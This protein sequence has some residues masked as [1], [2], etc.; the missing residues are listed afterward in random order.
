MAKIFFVVL[1]LGG[2]LTYLGAPALEVAAHE[3]PRGEAVAGGGA[4]GL[5]SHSTVTYC[6]GWACVT[7]GSLGLIFSG[8]VRAGF[9]SWLPW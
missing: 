3:A 9:L 1:I 7:V 2:L 8:V 4:S 5:H 6:L